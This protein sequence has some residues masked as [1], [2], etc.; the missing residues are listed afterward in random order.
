MGLDKDLSIE[1]I[2]RDIE[3]LEFFKIYAKKYKNSAI[4]VEATK[5][6]KDIKKTLSERI[7]EHNKR[8]K[9]TLKLKELL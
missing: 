4:G 6:V 8:F 1:E 2:L 9:D 5:T 3:S 7:K